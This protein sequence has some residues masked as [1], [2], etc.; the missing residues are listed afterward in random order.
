MKVGMSF[1]SES[2]ATYVQQ[3]PNP[4]CENDK[5]EQMVV[6]KLDGSK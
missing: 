4:T 3:S 1:A 6:K 2:M 5:H